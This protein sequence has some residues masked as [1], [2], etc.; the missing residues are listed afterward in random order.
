M[1]TRVWCTRVALACLA[2]ACGDQPT[3][4]V[5]E[6]EIEMGQGPGII[7][8]TTSSSD[9]GLSITT[10]KDD[11]Q[12]GD[13]VWLTGSGWPA[14]DTLDIQLD[15]EPATHPPH[16]WW[17]PV[18]GDGTFRDSTYLVDVDDIGVTF[19]LTAT[20]R[21]TGRSLAV[22]FTDGN[23]TAATSPTT[24]A[25]SGAQ[26]AVAAKTTFTLGETVCAQ[27]TITVQTPP[28]PATA[29]VRFQWVG[30][31]P[32][33]TIA[34]EVIKSGVNGTTQVDQFAPT[35]TGTWTVRVCNPTG[36]CATGALL[37]SSTFSVSAANA[38]TATQVTSSQNPSAFGDAV[39]FTATVTSGSPATAVTAGQVS[40]KT[41]G[42]SC[43]D[44]TQMQAAQNV[45]G[46]G[47]VTFTTSGLAIGSHTIRACY[48]GAPG[49]LAG[50][51]SVTQ[52]VN[53]TATGI[54]LTSSVN[55]S[56]TGQSV[57]FTATVTNNSNPVTSGQ[58]AFKKGGTDCS[59]A[60]QVQAPQTPNGS[61]QV[62]YSAAFAASQSPVTIH[63]CFG[64]STTPT[65]QP[66]EAALVQTI[67]KASTTTSV[68]SSQNPSVFSQT[69][70]FTVTV[71]V[72][73]PGVGTPAGNVTLK[74]GTCAAGTAIGGPTALNGSGQ[75]TFNVSTLS[76]GSHDVTGCYA[77]N[78]DFEES[79]GFVA[80]TVNKAET[81]TAISSNANPSVF[82]QTVTFTVTVTPTAPASATPVGNV[83]LKNGTCAAGASL[84]GPTALNGGGVASFNVSSLA[85][86]THTITACYLGNANFEPSEDD[87]SQVVN[88]AGTSTAVSSSAN[89]SILAQPVTFDVTVSPVA[90]AV[91]I[92]V[93]NVTLKD[94]TCATGA[95]IDGTTALDG[96]GQVS[97]SVSTLSAGTHTV[98]ACYA[99]NDSFKSS[100]GFLSQQVQYNFDG[101]F[102]PVDRPNTLN[103]S[104][105]GQGIPL[106]WRLTNYFG[107]PVLD[108]APAAFGVAVS[109]LQ[110]TV[111][112]TLDQVEEYAGNS[113]LQ[114]LGDGYYQFNWKTPASYANSCK[115]IGLNLGEGSPRGPLAYFNF[116]K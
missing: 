32:A 63:A 114:N 14:N 59:D 104:K 98:T 102:A 4:V 73:S 18:L 81:S 76:A 64:G 109:G 21:R 77:G 27:S 88:K 107:A 97:F 61:G 70:T 57:T 30:P 60:A 22:Q 12:P 86:G 65:L 53:N 68:G 37:A 35:G 11:Y 74:D 99:G 101:L 116:K 31:A 103:V 93:G 49:F 41:G 75:A 6:R 82:S 115:A 20:S 62:T 13:T 40:F 113:G 25:P 106:K 69:V 55:P 29:D 112:A 85:V 92:P 54:D 24:H 84:G 90:P 52:E 42:T 3:E 111:S 9:D 34:R 39:T 23:I 7:A 17:V 66:S 50:E 47:Q 78:G 91:A 71:A 45:N 1:R 56:R 10:D 89:P 19:T 79:N 36:N 110:C 51:G 8:L 28:A 46:S 33:T 2:I 43:S 67:N 5:P 26:C 38:A 80:Q 44:A 72:V 108:F 87:V 100:Y 94:G 58:V 16:T 15:D 48:G 83:T 96:S 105:A 95:T